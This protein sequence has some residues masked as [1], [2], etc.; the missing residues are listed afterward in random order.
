MTK[1]LR[2]LP[3]QSSFTA[4][5]VGIETLMAIAVIEVVKETTE[6]G[7]AV[8]TTMLSMAAAA[9]AEEVADGI[10]QEMTGKTKSS[11]RTARGM[12]MKV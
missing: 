4:A 9:Q 11:A 8:V 7:I 6:I 5:V 1:L 2:L 3:P 10:N 12:A